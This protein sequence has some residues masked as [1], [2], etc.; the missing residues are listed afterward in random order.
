MPAIKLTR[1]E[2]EWYAA[3]L[4][5]QNK[6][7]R[8]QGGAGPWTPVNGDESERIMCACPD[9]GCYKA[10]EW[11]GTN[12]TIYTDVSEFDAGLSSLFTM[13]DLPD[14]VR[15]CRR[16]NPLGVAVPDPLAS[17]VP[18]LAEWPAEAVAWM[19]DADGYWQWLVPSEH[20]VRLE[21]MYWRER[22]EYMRCDL[23]PGIAPKD[24]LRLRPKD[25]VAP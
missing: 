7:L 23:P 6:E 17:I 8:A 19:A 1:A 15:L 16:G 22:G 20:N 21:L 3:D 12:L 5:R 25:E 2:L 11:D 9:E 10:I 13:I 24:T 4:E 18:P 14:D